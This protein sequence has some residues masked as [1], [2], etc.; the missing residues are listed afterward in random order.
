MWWGFLKN[1]MTFMSWPTFFL[2]SHPKLRKNVELTFVKKKL[3]GKMGR[4]EVSKLGRGDRG[5]EEGEEGRSKG[6]AREEEG[7]E[8]EKKRREDF[9]GKRRIFP[10]IR[11]DPHANGNFLHSWA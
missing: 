8:R 3:K 6:G 7:E 9:F 10:P 1:L 11:I 5:G 4:R 2:P